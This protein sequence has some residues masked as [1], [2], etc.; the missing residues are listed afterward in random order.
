MEYIYYYAE[1][2][3]K[4]SYRKANKIQVQSLRA[5]QII[6][7]KNQIFSGTVLEISQEINENGFILEPICQ[8]ID[9]KWVYC[10]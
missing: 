2:S 8:K 1:L 5:A 3:N 4:N 7:S 9:G 6:A 10:T